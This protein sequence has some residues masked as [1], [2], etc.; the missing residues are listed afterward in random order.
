MAAVLASLLSALTARPADAE[1]WADVVD[2]WQYADPVRPDDLAAEAWA[3]LLRAILCRRGA[4]QMRADA[5]EAV[6]R[7]AAGGYTDP[8]PLALHG[9]ALVLS[10][11]LDGGDASFQ[12]AADVSDQ[13]GAPEL[14]LLPLLATHLSFPQ[15][16]EELFLSRN[17]IK[18]QAISIYRKLGSPPGVPQSSEPVNWGSWRDD[19]RM[20]Q[21]KPCSLVEVSMACGISHGHAQPSTCGSVTDG[22]DLGMFVQGF[23][24]LVDGGLEVEH[25]LFHGPGE[26]V[27][28]QVLVGT[29]DHEPVVASDV[30]ASV[31]GERYRDG[32]GHLALADQLAVRPQGHRSA[33]PGLGL[34]RVEQHLHPHVTRGNGLGRCL[35]VGL[36]AEEGVGVVQD[37]VVVDP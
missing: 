29:V 24:V 2:R 27:G 15:I 30:Q 21:R 34:V 14:R 12:D 13:T 16:G 18:S 20:T 23:F 8:A 26:G 6:R 37:P 1:R 35:L 9:I 7:F 10:G 5:A 33:G 31:A 36:H 3:A 19:G 22:L 32:T 25:H 28:G 11:D 17:T 4:G